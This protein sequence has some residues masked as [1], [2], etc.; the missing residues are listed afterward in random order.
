MGQFAKNIVLGPPGVSL[1][2]SNIKITG[3]T[4]T[5]TNVDQD[6][7]LDPNGDGLVQII[8][9]GAL[10]V[11][12]GTGAQ[13]PSSP[14]LGMLRANSDANILEFYDGTTWLDLGAGGGGG[15]VNSVFG[16]TGTVVSL[17]GDYTASKITNVPAGN[18]AATNV[19]AAIAELDNEKV[20]VSR[21]LTA[22]LGL[23]GGGTLSADRIFDLDFNELTTDATGGEASDYLVFVDTSD[24]NTSEKVLVSD[25]ITNN[26]LV[27]NDSAILLTNKSLEDSTT[28]FVDDG[29]NTKA[30]RFQLSGISTATTRVLTLPN[31]DG[32]ILLT[33]DIPASA[34]SE[35]NALDALGTGYVVKTADATYANRQIVG[36]TSQISATNTSGSL[37]NTQI[38]LAD[39]A[40]LPGIASMT[41]PSGLT[42]DRP[43]SPINGMVRYNTTLNKVEAREGGAWVELSSGGG[44]AVSSVFTRSGA[45]VAVA[46]DY[47]AS[48]ITNVAGG[49]V[50]AVTVQAAIDELAS[51]K[52]SIIGTETLTNKSL[53]DA[54]TQFI[55]NLDNTKQM[56]FQV[57]GVTTGTTRTLTVP[58]ENTTLVGTAATQTLANKTL[59]N[60][61]VITLH[62]DNFTL[63][64][65]GDVTKQLQFQLSSITT[66]NTRIITVPDANTIL[67]GTDVAQT[68]TNKTIV[69]GSN[70]I[71]GLLHGTQVDNPSSGVHGVTGSVVGTTDSQTLTTKVLDNTNTV[72]LHDDNFT[73]QDE[74]DVTKQVNFQ[75]S[76]ITTGNTRVLTVQDQNGTIALLSDLSAANTE[77][78]IGSANSTT[79]VDGIEVGAGAVN[80]LEITNALT[81][82]APSLVA[83]GTDTN[84]DLELGVKGT[85]VIRVIGSSGNG[86]INT[87]STNN[88]LTVSGT[89]AAGNAVFNI[90]NAD[91][92]ATAETTQGT[93]LG[94]V[95]KQT[96]D[97]GTGYNDTT[98][99]QILV[100]KEADFFN[101][102]GTGDNDS[103]MAVS[104]M[105]NGTLSEQ[106]RITSAQIEFNDQVDNTKIAAFDMSGITTATTR[107]FTFPDAAGTLLTTTDIPATEQAELL[108]IDALAA[109]MVAK[110]ADAAY[111]ARTITGTASEIVIT[112]G[113]GI[114][115]N[116]VIGIADDPIFTGTTNIVVPTGTTAQ[117]TGTTNGAIRYDS[118]DDKFR[119]RQNGVWFD[120]TGFPIS[121]YIDDDMYGG[122]LPTTGGQPIFKFIAVDPFVLDDEFLGA[123]GHSEVAASGAA[124]T[125]NVNKNGTKIGEISIA[126][127]ATVAT[128][129]TTAGTV[130]TFAAGDR[131]EVDKPTN[132]QSTNMISITFKAWRS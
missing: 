131:L 60:T 50:I 47:T 64:D 37:G 55:D 22:G 84:I 70:T 112:N 51:E 80:Y 10:V 18:I 97:S 41:L 24:T 75:L 26:L 54:T 83:A 2:L 118:D 114:A 5:T 104:T 20:A 93:L 46:G 73:L 32:T 63:Q 116:P 59:D 119:I 96:S 106:M 33:S 86:I 17:A 111:A 39:N 8:G 21:T 11:P 99:A 23:S 56:Q 115:A 34:V 124:V 19:Q 85:G 72:T 105:L 117:E 4:I 35:L 120:L 61:N 28:L 44:G 102:A 71:T 68:L 125:F 121:F 95:L 107:T 58:N 94:F 76:G 66:A 6:M 53:V 52:A 127:A 130:E 103:F 42:G 78:L 43:G 67:V 126:D 74:G 9:T 109:G 7:L 91:E 57:S 40:I 101:A 62:D 122:T 113:D 31:A 81:S 108:A 77:D 123:Q 65:E 12:I 69:A 82:V 25:F 27:D 13:Q 88:I 87:A 129:T 15:S 16:R 30:F 14:V 92:G 45:V 38:S 1:I 110:T 100:G 128:F 48:E 3:N 49:T 98:A 89:V 29:D 36:T 132:W 79:I 90:R